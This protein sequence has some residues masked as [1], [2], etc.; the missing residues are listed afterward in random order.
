MEWEPYKSLFWK[1]N[2]SIVKLMVSITR[3]ISLWYRP[4]YEIF[5]IMTTITNAENVRQYKS[6][7]SLI[8]E[9]ILAFTLSTNFDK[10]VKNFSTNFK[11]IA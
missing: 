4:S 6:R 9:Q 5:W 1:E 7:F 11:W 3:D 8:V 2:D 10:E